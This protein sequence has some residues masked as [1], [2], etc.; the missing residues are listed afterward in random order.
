MVRNVHKILGVPTTSAQYRTAPFFCNWGTEAMTKLLPL[1]CSR[2]M[3][4]LW[5]SFI[6]FR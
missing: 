1:V 6:G 2:M 4:K 5:Q 3:T